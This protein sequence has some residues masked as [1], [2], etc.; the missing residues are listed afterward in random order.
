M[1]A[2]LGE[3]VKSLGASAEGL[4][5]QLDELRR[6]KLQ[7]EEA[8]DAET[9]AMTARNQQ[10]A[11]EM[12]QLQDELAIFKRLGLQL[13]FRHDVVEGAE[14]GAA[15]AAAAAG[16]E[17]GADADA[18][19]EA[20]AE[21]GADARTYT[22]IEFEFTQIDGSAP[23]R[24]F[25]FSLRLYEDGDE[26]YAFDKSDPR[27]PEENVA[28]ELQH[29]NKANEVGL[30][31]VAAAAAALLLPLL[32]VWECAA[33]GG[34]HRSQERPCFFLIP[35]LSSPLLL[36]SPSLL[37]LLSPLFYPPLLSS[38][39]L[40]PP[41]YSAHRLRHSSDLSSERCGASSRS[42]CRA[43]RWLAM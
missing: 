38:P 39:P 19:A 2:A 31:A 1:E 36:C 4:P 12:S 16:A 28:A 22:C 24:R 5:A 34:G 33:G 27:V 15:A 20:K 13:H 6:R 30:V 21:L 42:L 35:V 40:P 32:L 29:A 43:A 25:K 17:G 9:S 8:L 10:S 26:Q 23:D 7:Q 41:H 11:H 3:E 18:E 37:L 14:G